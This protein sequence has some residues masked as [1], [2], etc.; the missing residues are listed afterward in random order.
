MV[1]DN[2][3]KV[4]SYLKKKKKKTHMIVLKTAFMIVLLHFCLIQILWHIFCHQDQ[5]TLYFALI[6]F[7]DLL[8][9]L[10]FRAKP[11]TG[12]VG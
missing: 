8:S 10:I 4:P 9:V 7:I 2:S 3:L 1:L 11:P 6:E 12:T 5:D